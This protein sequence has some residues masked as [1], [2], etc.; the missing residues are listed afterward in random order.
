M[1][2]T[3]TWL[4]EHR[5]VTGFPGPSVVAKLSFTKHLDYKFANNTGT[6]LDPFLFM[7]LSCGAATL[8]DDLQ[9]DPS[10]SCAQLYGARQPPVQQQQTEGD[11][12]R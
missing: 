7:Y 10:L 3:T 4:V 8:L 12:H 2:G 6:F 1:Q 11:F 5:C 9:P